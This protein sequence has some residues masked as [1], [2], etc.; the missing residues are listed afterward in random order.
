MMT[1]FGAPYA[2][3]GVTIA[4][5]GASFAPAQTMKQLFGGGMATM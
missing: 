4:S 2:P 1:V 3:G 5:A